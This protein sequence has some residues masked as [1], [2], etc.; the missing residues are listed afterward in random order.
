MKRLC[1]LL[2]A[3]VFSLVAFQIEAQEPPVEGDPDPCTLAQETVQDEVGPGDTYRNHGQMVRTA[4]SLVTPFLQAGSISLECAGCIISQ[5]A[6]RIPIDEQQVCEGGEQPQEQE[7][8]DIG[9]DVCEEAQVAAQEAV[10][11][12]E[13]YRNH[14]QMVRTAARALRPEVISAEITEECAGCIISQFAR[15]IPI[16]EQET[17]GSDLEPELE[18]CCLADGSC[19]DLSRDECEAQVGSPAGPDTDCTTASCPQPEACCFSDR[20]CEDRTSDDCEASAGTP[21]GEG[22]SCAE[23]SCP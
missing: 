16:E 14:G 12:G 11:D 18:A 9:S 22:T 13:P 2:L 4:A 6:R 5:F 15:R 23:A 1:I 20:S 8:G 10:A 7:Q 19:A 3:A 21:Q 17:C